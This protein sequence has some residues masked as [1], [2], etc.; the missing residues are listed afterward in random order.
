MA[1]NVTTAAE[2][3][4]IKAAQMVKVREVDFVER[5]AGSI[6]SK[7]IEA[8]G[9]TRKV[10]LMEGTSLYVY[11][12]VG[13]L[14]SGEVPEGEIIPLSQYERT[15]QQI[16]EITIK[17]WRKA[18][19]AEAIKKSG[20]N[21]AVNETD[22]KMLSDIQ[23]GIRSDFFGFLNGLDGTVVGASTL[24]A[25]LAK[26]WGQLQVLFE[27]DAVE[28]VHFMNPLTIAD[29]LATATISMQTAF[30]MN[31]VEDFLGMGTVILNSQIP[32]GHVISTAKENIIMYYLT[33]N[34]E[35]AQAFNLTADETGYIGVHSSQT[36]NRA[37]L[38]ILAMSGIQFL[39][40]YADGVVLGQI[41]N[42][43]T[44]GSLTVASEASATTS[45]K[46]AITVSGYNPGTGE[47]LK[48]K[49]AD[50]A[51]SVTYGQNLKNWTSW[52]GTDEITAATGKG[53]TVAY[54][55]ANYRA[56]AAGST[57]V[58]AKA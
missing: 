11:K 30:G 32:V 36:D 17:K 16:G 18:V 19:T 35:V 42:T 33:M 27:N 41:D 49:V 1:S 51:P 8:L 55:D 38:E 58:T 53:I 13:T 4:V 29:Y 28:V 23:T 44:L 5:F 7:L 54:V 34:G 48:Y 9:V 22:K 2:T 24:Q 39:V 56:Q 14:Q 6:L 47:T 46:T 45:G 40:E 31:Y 12:T 10:P 21:E 26:T 43:P 52:N 3:N 57:T 50:T 15:K 37:Q 20:Y 25:V